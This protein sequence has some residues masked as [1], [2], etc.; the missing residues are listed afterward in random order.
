VEAPCPGRDYR[1]VVL[2]DEI[3]SAYE[4]RPLGVVGD[5]TSTIGE[6]V[7]RARAG[8]GALGRPNSEI[9]PADWRIDRKLRSHDLDRN[10]V[11][12]RGAETMLLDNANLSTGGTSVDI[13]GTLHPSFAA[14]AIR[15]TRTIGLKFAGVDIICADAT[16][17][18]AGQSWAILELNAA[19]GLDNYAATGAEQRERVR[20]MYLK[21]MRFLETM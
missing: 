15:A 14:E 5:G 21:I 13:T 8:L 2:G 4:R 20:L 12:A 3:I 1:I 19:P 10:H 9:E 6:L 7:E 18:A 11:P 16:A 17:D